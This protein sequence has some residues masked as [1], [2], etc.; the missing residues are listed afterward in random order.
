MST[1]FYNWLRDRSAGVLLHPTSLPG[2]FAIG[3]FSKEAYR[4]VDFLS[5]TSM[6]YWQVCPLGPTGYGDSPYQCF[7]S[8]A[9]NPYL[10]DP[11]DLC[12]RGLLQ[13]DSLGPLLFLDSE[14]VDYGGLYEVKWPLLFQACQGFR[15][16]PKNKRPYGDFEDF[17]NENSHWLE[18]YA[19]FHALKQ[20]HDGAPWY[21]WPENERSF[22]RARKSVKDPEVLERVQDHRILQYLFDGQWQRLKHYAARHGVRIIG[23]VPIYA[24]AD[25][26]DV[27][28]RPEIFQVDVESGRLLEVA[29]VPPDYFSET[30]QL[31]GNPLYNWKALKASGYQWWLERIG[32]NLELY[33]VVRI[34]HF[35]GF[36]DYWSIPSDAPDARGGRWL[37]GPDLAFFKAVKSAYPK[38]RL[39]A[40]DLGDL[41]DGVFKLRDAVGLPGMAILQFAFG[42]GSDNLYLPHNHTRNSV[43]YPGTHDNDTSRGWYEGLDR[44]TGD[45]VRRYYRISGEEIAWDLLRSA[46]RSP[47]R[48]AIVPLQDLLNLGSDARMN[49][50]GTAE[51][52]WRWRCGHS[53]IDRLQERSGAYLA[54]LAELY[55]RS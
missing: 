31:W 25:S 16:L 3:S 21:Q 14:Q 28:S 53:D 20:F 4:F 22:E 41:S 18:A 32:R 9:G 55:G 27:W 35:R 48:L 54:E 45:H 37:K 39:I 23:D 24:A 52:N 13:A 11:L 12:E 15:R 34:D 36:H 42:G 19:Y 8:F 43:V 26:A 2:D 29:G 50:P 1:P 47:A 5:E 7:S 17:Q 40:E 10:I 33:D 38:A 6:S 44:K 51:G 49:L 46:Y 30:G